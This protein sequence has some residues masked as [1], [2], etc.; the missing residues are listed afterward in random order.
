MFK[1]GMI[2][3]AIREFEKALEIEPNLAE[4]QIELGCLLVDG[5][6]L[7]E[8]DD[9]LAKGLDLLP[10]DLQ[11]QI[12]SAQVLAKE[13]DLDTA[14][15]DL[16]ALLFRHARSPELH[17]SLADVYVR[18]G[19]HEKAADEFKKAYDLLLRKEMME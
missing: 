9:M 10:D 7:K 17:Y 4:A 14:M 12:C 16:Q 8:G 2:E 3:S 13:G 1:R 15:Q 19:Q 5:G 18:K 11:G 6:K